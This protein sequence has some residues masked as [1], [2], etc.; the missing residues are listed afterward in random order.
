MVALERGT[1]PISDH[2][3]AE[4]S[5]PKNTKNGSDSQSQKV[6]AKSAYRI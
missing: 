1:I 3:L 4:E 5:A 2:D 6:F